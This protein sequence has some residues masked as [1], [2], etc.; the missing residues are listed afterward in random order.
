M[1]S[2]KVTKKDYYNAIIA[3]ARGEKI[4][5][6]VIPFCEKEIAA[7]DQRNVKAK[8]RAAK[9]RAEGDAL[10]DAV[11]AVLTDEFATRTQVA[12]Q[13][14]PALEASVAKVGFRLNARVE[15]G[16]AVKESISVVGE[17][18]KNKKVMGYKLA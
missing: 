2:V 1:D 10:Q 6:D 7:L 12:E 18:G 13:I 8:E 3:L 16:K 14:D 15:A 11:Y 4:D 5:V 9:K 17:D